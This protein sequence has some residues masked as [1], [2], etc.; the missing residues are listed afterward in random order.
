MHKRIELSDS[1][2][3][4]LFAWQHCLRCS[5]GPRDIRFCG[6]AVMLSAW[7]CLPGR[8]AVSLLARAR[9]LSGLPVSSLAHESFLLAGFLIRPISIGCFPIS[10]YPVMALS[11]LPCPRL[12]QIVD[13]QNPIIQTLNKYND[14]IL[15]HS[16]ACFAC[17]ASPHWLRN[18]ANP[19]GSYQLCAAS[20]E[21][22][23]CRLPRRSFSLDTSDELWAVQS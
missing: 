12:S 5:R 22:V 15:S 21:Y 13:L 23:T 10:A 18:S 2:G 16:L 17:Q 11:T 4:L 20:V 9:S 14:T 3:L 6:H 7:C 19:D 1:Q 8:S